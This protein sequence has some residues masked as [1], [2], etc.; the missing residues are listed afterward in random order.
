MELCSGGGAVEWVGG[1]C[2]LVEW[3]LWS[4]WVGPME[5]VNGTVLC[6]VEK[7]I[8]MVAPTK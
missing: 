1:A 3:G 7:N 4:G 5:S 6:K 8:I 2:G